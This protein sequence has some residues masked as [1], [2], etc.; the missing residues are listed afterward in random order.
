MKK[1]A[2]VWRSFSPERVSEARSLFTRIGKQLG[3]RANYFEIR[4]SGEIID[5]D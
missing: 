4:E 3:Q 1:Q 2:I 5:L